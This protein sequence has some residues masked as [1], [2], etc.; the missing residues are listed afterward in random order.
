MKLPDNKK[1]MDHNKIEPINIT[2]TMAEDPAM[3]QK[4][5]EGIKAEADRMEEKL[6]AREDLPSLDKN[7]EKK[8][9]LYQDIVWELKKK[10][11]WE[12]EPQE[13]PVSHLSPEDRQA[14]ELGRQ[15]LKN[16]PPTPNPSKKHRVL[17]GLTGAA[18]VVFGIF[19]LSMTSE[20]NRIRVL[21]VWNSI[22]G[23]ELQVD[24]DNDEDINRDKVYE[25]EAYDKIKKEL[26]IEP[27]QFLYLPTN[28]QYDNYWIDEKLNMA[29]LF[30]EYDNKIFTVEMIG[31]TNG[32]DASTNRKF[33]GEV[34]KTINTIKTTVNS[35][36]IKIQE[37]NNDD[38]DNS[39]IANFIYQ[40]VYYFFS[41]QIPQKEF[42][43][44][45]VNICF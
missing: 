18:V 43:E 21:S 14:L 36:E 42:E 39:F 33:D 29:S 20:A 45:I 1:P 22:V 17:K 25:Q 27:V 41:G 3:D 2:Q 32:I 12:E 34:L 11:L 5:R 4:L 7:P 24:F 37:I 6:S 9:K 40:N 15:L 19:G 16:Q 10:G 26:N 8:E 35:I 44:I 31:Q 28:M 30:Y 23:E 13:D 38:G